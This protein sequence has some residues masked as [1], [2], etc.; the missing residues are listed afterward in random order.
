MIMMMMLDIMIMMLDMMIMMII[1]FS[2]VANEDERTDRSG[3]FYMEN[4]CITGSR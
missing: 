4:S 3:S 2:T 1:I